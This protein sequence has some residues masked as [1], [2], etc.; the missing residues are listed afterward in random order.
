MGAVDEAP[1]VLAAQRGPV[2]TSPSAPVRW[3]QR[4]ALVE[5]AVGEQPAPRGAA[6]GC[7]LATLE[8]GVLR[9]TEVLRGHLWWAAALGRGL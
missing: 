1:V 9:R 5:R 2:L 3:W 6:P 8:N 7:S 4:R